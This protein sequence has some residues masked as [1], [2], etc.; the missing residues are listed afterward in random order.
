[1]LADLGKT[2]TLKETQGRIEAL[3]IDAQRLSYTG[4][5]VHQVFDDGR[6][7]TAPARF[8]E[9]RNIH[10]P[11][12]L[13]EMRD[14]ESS[15]RALIGKNKLVFGIRVPGLVVLLLRG[16]LHLQKRFLLSFRPGH[17][18]EF[19]AARAAVDFDQESFVFLPDGAKA[20]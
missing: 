9:K 5:F 7:D 11:N 2:Q 19:L 15:D 18:G 16:Q 13:I 6:A 14:V 12:L 3:D 1:M 20:D 4:R 17:G 8:C 10:N